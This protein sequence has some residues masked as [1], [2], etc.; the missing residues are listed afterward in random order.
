M[1]NTYDRTVIKYELQEEM[2][3]KKSKAPADKS[4]VRLL[5]LIEGGQDSE[6]VLPEEGLGPASRRNGAMKE[7]ASRSEIAPNPDHTFQRQGLPPEKSATR[8]IL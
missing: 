8:L 2:W 3:R 4:P 1:T 7:A 5:K 6:R